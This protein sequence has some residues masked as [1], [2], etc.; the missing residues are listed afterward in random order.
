MTKNK[1]STLKKSHKKRNMD[2]VNVKIQNRKKKKGGT[3]DPIP[4]NLQ[5]SNSL[6]QMQLPIITQDD[7]DTLSVKSNTNDNNTPTSDARANQSVS[8]YPKKFP[9]HNFAVKSKF[10]KITT[11]N[12]ITGIRAVHQDSLISISII[13]KNVVNNF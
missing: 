5:K 1:P 13:E 4:S 10:I 7:E 8:S 11:S 9:M 6:I 3:L 12:F 2:V